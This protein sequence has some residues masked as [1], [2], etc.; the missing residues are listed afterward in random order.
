MSKR[1]CIC[2][3][4]S[5]CLV[6]S[7]FLSLSACAKGALPTMPASAAEEWPVST[8]GEQDL[9]A[10]LLGQMVETIEE[11]DYDI[12]SVL[13][14]RNGHLV[15]DAYFSPFVPDTKHIIHSCTK[16]VVSILI[17]IAIEQGYIE[18][19][20]QPVL[21]FFPERTAA[22]TDERKQA[23]TLEDLLT[24]SSGLACQDSYLYRW[25]GLG[26]MRDSEDWVQHVLD[27]PMADSPGT[28]FEYCNGGSF[29][30]SAILQETTGMSALAYAREHLF[31]PLGIADVSWPANPAGIHMGWGEMHLRP[32][33][34]AKIG[35]LYL[36]EGQWQGQ[37]I[38]PA[39]WVR[40]STQT[41]IRAGTLSDG[42]GY[43]WWVDERGYYI[44][45]GYQGQF[46]YVVPEK[47]LVVVFTSEL[48]DEDFFLPEMLLNEYVLQAVG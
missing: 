13:V 24:M 34:M 44:A 12:D 33:D 32:H 20:D 25:R 4:L 2:R 41:H 11:E 29:L 22:H 9:D 7:A 10:G 42:Y 37:Q 6:S 16:S 40:A 15:L 1:F 48:A 14:L 39:D 36:D 28:R 3:L 43:Q 23:M 8:P 38:V 21:S 31:G 45:I 19:V 27:L 5:I 17:G 46:I 47:D 18:G 30:L 26:E 35:Q